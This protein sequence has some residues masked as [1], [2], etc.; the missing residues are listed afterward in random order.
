MML[1]ISLEIYQVVQYG[2]THIGEIIWNKDYA[3]VKNK[4]TKRYLSLISNYNR[5]NKSS[6]N[7]R[8]T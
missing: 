8:F 5:N 6:R 3:H 2:Q 4:K 7:K 1:K